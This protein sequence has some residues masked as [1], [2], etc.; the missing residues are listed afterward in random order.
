DLLARRNVLINIPS[1]SRAA[2]PELD[3]IDTILRY[4]GVDS[5]GDSIN[6]PRND[7]D[8]FNDGESFQNGQ[9]SAHIPPLRRS[10][11]F[12]ERGDQNLVNDF[13][14]E[15]TVAKIGAAQPRRQRGRPRSTASVR[16]SSR[17]SK[18]ILKRSSSGVEFSDE[19][20]EESRPSEAASK[21]SKAKKSVTKPTAKKPTKAKIK[22][23]GALFDNAENELFSDQER[24]YDSEHE[25][26]DAEEPPLFFVARCTACVFAANE[27]DVTDGKV[28]VNAAV[29]VPVYGVSR[30]I[31][32][33]IDDEDTA[34][35]KA[36][37]YAEGAG[38]K[39]GKSDGKF[40]VFLSKPAK[41]CEHDEQIC[42]LE[43]ENVALRARVD[44]HEEEMSKMKLMFEQQQRRLDRIVNGQ[45]NVHSLLR[46]DRRT[47]ETDG[48]SALSANQNSASAETSQSLL[49]SRPSNSQA[50]LATALKNISD[51][52]TFQFVDED[53]VDT[54]KKRFP[55]QKL[56]IRAIYKHMFTDYDTFNQQLPADK[57]AENAKICILMLNA[58]NDAK[59]KEIL[60]LIHAEWQHQRKLLRKKITELEATS[61]AMIDKPFALHQGTDSNFYPDEDVPFDRIRGERVSA[62]PILFK[63]GSMGDTMYAHR[64]EGSN[65]W[66]YFIITT[67]GIFIPCSK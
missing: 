15:A 8:T 39:Y 13:L 36:K 30:V 20:D 25:D 18:S 56:F 63:G 14:G 67:Q 31:Y 17:A 22:S 64:P 50:S 65:R 1:S 2:H 23:I 37:E 5:N 16:V 58:V 52:P 27:R 32:N 21:K 33:K 35:E 29:V 51:V 4:R 49:T 9:P 53:T 3:V 59:R 47:A 45:V 28:A 55:D 40:I 7:S 57:S 62:W 43:E 61:V 12:H 6:A 38:Y 26:E 42:A 34:V 54:L 66:S 10:S 19:E 48:T 11:R 44:K 24:L 60:E 46:D 41:P